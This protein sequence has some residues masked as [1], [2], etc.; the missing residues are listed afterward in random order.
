MSFISIIKTIVGVEHAITP[1]LSVIPGVGSIATGIDAIAQ[2]LI[3]GIATAEANNPA[4]GQGGIKAAAVVSDFQAGLELTQSVL[5]IE[6]KKLEYDA[7][8]LQTAI[9]AQ[10]AAF[11]AMAALKASF[12][13]TSL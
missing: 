5:A 9:N 8:M 7:A 11:N 10:V 1:I 6:H 13:V 12:R 3:G 2:R 4:D